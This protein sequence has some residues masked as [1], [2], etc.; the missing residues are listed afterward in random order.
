M[1]MQPDIFSIKYHY[2]ILLNIEQK[3]GGKNPFIQK[4]NKHMYNFEKLSCAAN[5]IFFFHN[6]LIGNTFKKLLNG[7]MGH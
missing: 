3:D 6:F 7:F 1:L 5:S 4:E 2:K